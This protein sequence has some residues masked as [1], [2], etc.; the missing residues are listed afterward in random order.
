[1]V[2][3]GRAAAAVAAEYAVSRGEPGL[4]PPQRPERPRRRR[5]PGSPE[6]VALPTAVQGVV[7]FQAG[8][9]A[10]RRWGAQEARAH[11]SEVWSA[12]GSAPPT[13]RSLGSEPPTQRRLGSDPPTQRGLGSDPPERPERPPRPAPP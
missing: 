1:M 7:E 8:G 2:P 10:A 3:E 9:V 13:L 4:G 12:P 5:A 11:W 6:V